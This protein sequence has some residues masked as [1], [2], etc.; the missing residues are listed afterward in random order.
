MM[1][2]IF[3]T[4]YT[5]MVAAGYVIE[6]LFGLTGLTPTE[7]NAQVIEAHFAWN[8]T[9]YLNIAFLLLAAALVT[10]FVRTGGIPM[11]KMMKAAPRDAGGTAHEHNG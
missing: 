1:L 10:R 8:Y 9:T 7:R 4:F 3:V 6:I 5:T 2:F 11:L